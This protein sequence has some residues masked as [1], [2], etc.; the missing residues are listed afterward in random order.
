M[1]KDIYLHKNISSKIVAKF[2]RTMS[3]F[4]QPDQNYKD[5]KCYLKAFTVLQTRVNLH[6][7]TFGRDA[8]VHEH[9]DLFQDIRLETIEQRFDFFSETQK[10]KMF[11]TL[12]M[13]EYV[14]ML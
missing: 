3:G 8:H 5:L 10:A 1:K 6:R 4:I 12:S 14:N 2:T 11:I 13:N 9:V 7:W